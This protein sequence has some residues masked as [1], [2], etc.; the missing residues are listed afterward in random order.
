MFVGSAHSH[1]ARDKPAGT[2]AGQTDDA[3]LDNST[4]APPTGLLSSEDLDTTYSCIF[5]DYDQD[6]R[7]PD[8][9]SVV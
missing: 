7:V 5:A 4:L 8:R 9:K 3:V 2:E 6:L 1:E